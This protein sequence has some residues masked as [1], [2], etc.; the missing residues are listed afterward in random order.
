MLLQDVACLQ[1]DYAL[2]A[3]VE[4]S[5]FDDIHAQRRVCLAQVIRSS[6]LIDV[7][8]CVASDIINKSPKVLFGLLA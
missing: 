5:V 3:G 7:Y 4:G 1:T 2:R 8:S 6:V